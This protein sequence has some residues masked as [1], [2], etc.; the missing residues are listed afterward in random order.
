MTDSPTK[1]KKMIDTIEEVKRYYGKVLKTH[2]DLRTTAC[3]SPEAL[4]LHLKAILDKI[5][6]E[7]LEKF[8]GCG[9]PIPLALEGKTILDLGCGSGRDVFLLS[10]LVGPSGR[11]IGVDMTESQLEIARRH[12]GHHQEAFGYK[13]ANTKFIKGYIE[14]LASIGIDD[15]SIDIAVSNCVFNLSPQKENV[16]EEIFRVLRPGGELYFSDIFTDRRLPAS[17]AEHTILLGECLGG[18]L[19]KE[20]FRRILQTL[21]C[22]DHRLISENP[23]EIRDREAQDL[24]GR[25]RFSSMTLR[26]FKLDLEDRCEDYGQTARYLGTIPHSPHAFLLDDHHLFEKGRFTSVCANTAAMLSQTRYRDHFEIAGDREVHYGL[27][28]C[29]SPILSSKSSGTSSQGCC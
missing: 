10:A 21:G 25:T 26:A 16:F 20:D 18:A 17:L 28:E 23:V 13:K 7:V 27:F 3:C 29:G 11:V 12:E 5:H 4:P 24:I 2:R 1:E 19:Y 8:Y 15:A 14:D 6:P 22:L 9:S